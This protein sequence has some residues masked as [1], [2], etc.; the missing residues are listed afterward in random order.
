MT[1][2]RYSIGYSPNRRTIGHHSCAVT[3]PKFA[4]DAPGSKETLVALVRDTI[5]GPLR[6]AGFRKRGR[7]WYRVVGDIISVVGVQRGE[8]RDGTI[9]FT[10]NWGITPQR[11]SGDQP[12]WNTSGAV[13]GRIGAFLSEPWDAWWSI[14]GDAVSMELRPPEVVE[15]APAENALVALVQDGFIPFASAVND[16]DDLRAAVA[17]MTRAQR[18]IAGT[19]PHLDADLRPLP[20]WDVHGTFAPDRP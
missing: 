5:D 11:F 2:N 14:R 12:P 10:V 18:A 13:A 20:G 17:A 9:R 15:G 6:S 19:A 8:E 16:E 7:T 4:A 1:T 3:V